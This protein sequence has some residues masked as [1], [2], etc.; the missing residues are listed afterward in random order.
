MKQTP[1][2][3]EVLSF[4]QPW[5]QLIHYSFWYSSAK[6]WHTARLDSGEVSS[7]CPLS[8]L[9]RDGMH[10]NV[11]AFSPAD[12]RC[13]TDKTMTELRENCTWRRCSTR[14]RLKL[15]ELAV[16]CLGDVGQLKFLAFQTFARLEY[17]C[18]SRER[19]FYLSRSRL[20]IRHSSLSVYMYRSISPD[21]PEKTRYYSRECYQLRQIASRYPR[22]NQKFV[23]FDESPNRLVGGY[24]IFFPLRYFRSAMWKAAVYA[25]PSWRYPAGEIASPITRK[26]R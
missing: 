24:D 18:P 1:F 8:V 25:Y 19:R 9:Q 3:S 11:T 26:H 20:F 4:Y 5:C 14:S 7:V 21:S 17:F 23:M 15:Y 13:N 2:I 22:W 10:E 12:V 16:K 6:V